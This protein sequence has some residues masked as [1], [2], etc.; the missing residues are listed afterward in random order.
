MR[1]LLAFAVCF[2]FINLP[3]RAASGGALV[4]RVVED[5]WPSPS[6][7]PSDILPG[8]TVRLSTD[9]AF[10]AG[11]YGLRQAVADS[12]GF[13]VFAA[14]PPDGYWFEVSLEGFSKR[15]WFVDLHSGFTRRLGVELAATIPDCSLG[16]FW[17]FSTGIDPSI[18]PSTYVYRVTP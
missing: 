4:V 10:G 13:A 12:L 18:P 9:H 15:I 17:D 16:E 3:A 7:G 1:T 14:V 8:A 2:L 6:M 11:R 5:R